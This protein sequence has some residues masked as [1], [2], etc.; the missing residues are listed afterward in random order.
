MKRIHVALY[1]LIGTGAFAI[2]AISILAPGVI[3]SAD[4][5]LTR[6]LG[7]SLI[8]VGLMTY[9]CIPNYERRRGVHLLLTVF[10]VLLA[11][12]HW[13]E[14]FLGRRSLISPVVNTIPFVLLLGMI[15]S[16]RSGE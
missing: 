16:K 10:A 3:P 9:W 2:G 6:E 1:A 12:I 4:D 13:Y 15:G 5:H 11:A 7:A 14:F 8:F